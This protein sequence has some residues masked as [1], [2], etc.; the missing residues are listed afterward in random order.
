MPLR[1]SRLEERIENELRQR[2]IAFERQVPVPITD[3]LWKISRSKTSPKC[4]FYLPE[5]DLYIEVKGLYD[6]HG[7]V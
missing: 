5:I 4:D 6:L 7:C 1:N 3:Y 2:G